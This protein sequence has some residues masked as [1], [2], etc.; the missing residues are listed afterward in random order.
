MQERMIIRAAGP[1]V[2]V[3]LP[4]DIQLVHEQ[5]GKKFDDRMR[6]DDDPAPSYFALLPA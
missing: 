4:I 1:H 5:P 2:G 3:Q 6:A